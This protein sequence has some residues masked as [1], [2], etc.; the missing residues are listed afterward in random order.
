MHRVDKPIPEKTRGE[1]EKKI[2]GMGDYVKMS[3]LQRA[4]RSKL[5]YDTKKF[6][7]LRLAGVYEARKMFL[8]SA[9]LVKSAGEIN[10]TFKDKIKDYIKAVEL[11]IKGGDFVEADR[12]FS[13]ALALGN[14]QEKFEM[15]GQLKN[16][17]ITQAKLYLKLDRRN[18]AKLTC[19][20]ILTLDLNIGERNEIKK[21]L[22]E[23][24]NKLG[25]VREYYSLRDKV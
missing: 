16:F 3:Y 13:Q 21:T 8:E 14:T 10:T 19:E 9:R 4:L 20:K 23:L 24:Y 22:L 1:I 15:K 7:L 12:I 17:Y 6:V 25:N 5:D 11:N 18:H 2:A